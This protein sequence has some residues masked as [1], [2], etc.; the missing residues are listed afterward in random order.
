MTETHL[1]LDN[2]YLGTLRHPV[3]RISEENG[4]DGYVRVTT[5]RLPAGLSRRGKR[6]AVRAAEETM[7]WGCHCEHDCCAHTFGYSQARMVG[8]RTMLIRTTV[9]RNI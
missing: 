1:Y 7:R 4:I 9:S 8:P 6:E 5:A 3:G 2:S